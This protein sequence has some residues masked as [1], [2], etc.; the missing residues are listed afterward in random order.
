LAHLGLA[1]V[2]FGAA[3]TACWLLWQR[4]RHDPAWRS[5]AGLTLFTAIVTVACAVIMRLGPSLPPDPPNDLNAIAGLL[6]RIPIVTW[7][8]W[9]MAVG[10][11]LLRPR[12]D[13]G[14]ATAVLAAVP[15]SGS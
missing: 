14:E 2:T 13:R 8:L 11:A 15:H 9:V 7:L 4:F 12:Q 6:Q 3:P 10:A 1:A 5:L